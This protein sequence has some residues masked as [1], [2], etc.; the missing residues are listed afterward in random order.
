MSKSIKGCS[1]PA[2][3][4]MLQPCNVGLGDDLSPLIESEPQ[5]AVF[6]YRHVLG[7]SEPELRIELGK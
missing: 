6:R 1:V 2:T 7:R 4:E 3:T 5:V